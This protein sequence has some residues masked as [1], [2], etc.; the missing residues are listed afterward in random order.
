MSSANSVNSQ[1]N[2]TV[3]WTNK[4]NGSNTNNITL[5]SASTFSPFLYGGMTEVAFDTICIAGAVSANFSGTT[6]LSQNVF[7]GFLGVQSANANNGNQI[8]FQTPGNLGIGVYMVEYGLTFGNISCICDVTYK[9]NGA[10]AFSALR[11][12]VDLYTN[13][14]DGYVVLFREFI[15]VTTAGSPLSIKWTANGK[16]AGSSNFWVRPCGPIRVT[17]LG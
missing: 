9:A 16:N 12:G 7:G 10:G 8:T 11:S 3:V 15:T 5:T 6:A 1:I 4:V 2:G 13:F 17:L 14:G